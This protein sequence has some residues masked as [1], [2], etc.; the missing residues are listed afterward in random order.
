MKTLILILTILY[1][2]TVDGQVHVKGY[3]RS[4]GT[5]VAPHTRSSPNSSPR[6][7]YS[8]PGNTNPYTGKTATGNPDTYVKNLYKNNS[9]QSSSD[10]WVD[11][12]YR[13]D[14]TYVT[15]HWR[16]APNSNPTDNFS[17]PGNTNPYTGKTA[18]GNSDTYLENYNNSTY[19]NSITYY[20]NSNTLN[21]RSGPS[22]NYSVLTSLSYGDNVEVLETTNSYWYKV[23]VGSFVGYVYSSYLNF[24]ISSDTNNDDFSTSTA[25]YS[26]TNNTYIVDDNFTRYEFRNYSLCIPN[27]MELRNEDSFMALSKEIMK[28][29][30]QIIKKIDIGDFN[31]VFQPAGTDDIQNS[32]KKKIALSLYSRVLLNYQKGKVEDFIRWNENIAFS[33][34]EYDEINKTF[35]DNLLEEFNK[36]KQMG[37]NTEL[38]SISDVKI[39]KNINKFV[40]V[41]QQYERRGLNGNIKV[42]DY[43]LHNNDEMVKLTISYRI[44]ESDLWKTDFDKIIDTFSFLTTK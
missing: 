29:K 25:D 15:G 8:Y 27:T 14:G 33:Q 19:N 32:E 6:D 4:N 39:A 40:Y 37:V 43:Y 1:S 16:S 44:S 35:K 31:F 5:Y 7:N 12:Y 41:Q 3:Y 2:L 20:V 21:L 30:L 38:L 9:S 23:K 26:N 17:Y 11:G 28:D 36:T 24:I 42:I 18:T 34:A 10:V 22:T 13:S